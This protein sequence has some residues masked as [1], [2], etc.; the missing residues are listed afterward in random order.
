MRW[1]SHELRLR[2][3][4]RGR[5]GGGSLRALQPA[6]GAII[7]A[8]K[9]TVLKLWCCSAGGP[10]SSSPGPVACAG[11]WSRCW[12]CP[13]PS[14]RPASASRPACRTAASGRNLGQQR[15]RKKQTRFGDPFVSVP[16]EVETQP[17]QSCVPKL[18]SC[19]HRV[20]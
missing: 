5:T 11:G 18:I 13:E 1:C 7:Y 4:A 10:S 17:R 9:K 14:R 8:D 19:V 6:Q 15:G 3:A 2:L 16:Q 20:T 12:C